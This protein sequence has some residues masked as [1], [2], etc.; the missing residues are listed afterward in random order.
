MVLVLLLV[1]AGLTVAGVPVAR[2][3][4]EAGASGADVEAP[5]PGP[6]APPAALP[7]VPAAVAPPVLVFGDSLGAEVGPALRDDLAPRI[8]VRV[9]SYP[10]AS[11]CDYLGVIA[12]GAVASRAAAVVLM[13]VGNTFSPCSHPEGRFPTDEEREAQV[14][15]ELDRVAGQLAAARVPLLIIGEGPLP[16]PF[17]L[18]PD[19][20]ESFRALAAQERIVGRDVIYVDAGA[21]LA[22]PEGWAADLPCLPWEATPFAGCVDGHIHV[23]SPDGRHLCPVDVTFPEVCPV[24]S[25]GAHRMAAAVADELSVRIATAG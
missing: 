11:L 23:R 2:P 17:A 1:L 3:T 21:T 19:L 16:Y 9:E 22:G 8:D 5:M 12:D 4:G 24:W 10:G 25:S 18:Q 15:A 14:L 20:N 6:V 7:V 13:F